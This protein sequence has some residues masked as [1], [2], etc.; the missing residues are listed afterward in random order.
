MDNVLLYFS[1]K[2][3]GDW[4]KIYDALDR[5]EKIE[6]QDLIKVPNSIPNN[7]ISIIN[8]L[9]PNNL[10]QIM[11]P[12]F[13][14]YYLGNI[15]LL[16]NYFQT[17]FIN[18]SDNIDEYNFKVIK[19]VVEDLIKENR[20]ILLSCENSQDNKLLDF[21]IEKQGK[22]I[23]VTKEP[24]QSF[25]NS[26]SWAK[27]K[28]IEY[29]DFIIISEYE[30]SNNFKY[31]SN[32]NK[33]EMNIR[34][35]NGLSKAIIFLEHSNFKKIEPLFN[36]VL[37]ENKPYF[38]IPQNLKDTESSSNNLLKNG[39]KLLESATDILNQI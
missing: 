8:P 20:T 13:I 24:L 17:I 6:T 12:P 16:Q 30:E 31:K 37:N 28:N 1:L 15:S 23:V 36:A 4:E 32:N 27:H 10:K 9:Y 35:I 2:Y 21:I 38:A 18:S 25:L 11:K 19:Q 7:F 33:E 34:I 14:L 29:S 22:L 5:K 26:E 3:H 39:A